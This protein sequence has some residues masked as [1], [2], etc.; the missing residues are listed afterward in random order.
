MGFAFIIPNIERSCLL[1]WLTA[2]T[3]SVDLVCLLPWLQN[4]V[5]MS[6]FV[7]YLA[8]SGELW[9]GKLVLDQACFSHDILYL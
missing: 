5:F 4:D 1:C 8:V 6:R 9:S 3:M 2:R 7:S